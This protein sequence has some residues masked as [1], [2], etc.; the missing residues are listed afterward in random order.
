MFFNVDDGT[1]FKMNYEIIENVL[2]ETTMF[3]HGNLS[4]NRW[5]YPSINIWKSQRQIKKYSGSAILAEFRGHGLSSAPKTISEINI[6][7]F[8]NDFL[9]LGTHLKLTNTNIIGHSTGGIVAAIMLS[10]NT[11][12]FNKAILLD[13]V[14]ANGFNLG[15]TRILAHETMRFNKNLTANAIGSVIY[16]NDPNNEFF[17]TVIVED[18]YKAV[19]L[20]GGAVFKNLSTLNVAND[21]K[22]INNQVLVIHGEKDTFLPIA[23]S[24][25]LANLIPKGIFRCIPEQGH[26]LNIENPEKFVEITNDFFFPKHMSS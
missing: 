6:H 21:V 4:S 8:V 19:K 15:I 5:W 10:K 18:A 14:G 26:C 17:N 1:D 2:P 13:P 16:G 22:N 25:E 20:I 9:E 7:T 3:L 23:S 11:T 12:M 24:Q